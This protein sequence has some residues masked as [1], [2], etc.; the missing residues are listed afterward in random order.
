[1]INNILDT[2]T[3]CLVLNWFWP[4]FLMGNIHEW[5]KLG[6]TLNGAR[7]INLCQPNQA[8]QSKP[9]ISQI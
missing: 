3:K 7:P 9:E 6:I 2:Y 8:K 1:M 5:T 4:Y